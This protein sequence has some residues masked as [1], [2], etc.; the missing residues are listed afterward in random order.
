MAAFHKEW[1][2]ENL[3][4]KILDQCKHVRPTTL[5][6][7]GAN[8]SQKWSHV[9]E[10]EVPAGHF[11][12]IAKTQENPQKGYMLKNLSL[13]LSRTTLGSPRLLIFTGSDT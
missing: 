3:L 1:L 4:K 9:R 10:T 2:L 12:F 7:I 13:V 6:Q 11:K 8:V 5:P